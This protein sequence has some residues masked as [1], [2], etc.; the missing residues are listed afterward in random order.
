MMALHNEMPTH[1]GIQIAQSI[2]ELSLITAAAIQAILAFVSL[3]LEFSAWRQFQQ[4][5][6]A[7]EDTP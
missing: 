2:L 5:A 6:D 4:E 3:C 7:E 1:K